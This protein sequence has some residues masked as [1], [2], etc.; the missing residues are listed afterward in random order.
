MEGIY[1]RWLRIFW[2]RK[3]SQMITTALNAKVKFILF[4]SSS[5]PKKNRF[6][7]IT[8]NSCFPTKKILLRKIQKSETKQQSPSLNHTKFILTGKIIKPFNC[9]KSRLQSS[10]RS[11]PLRRYRFRS[12]HSRV[13]KSNK[14]KVV[15]FQRFVC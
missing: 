7:S 8:P 1:W 4:R 12:L 13:Q 14:W 10:G 2:S 9:Q 15:W 5:L 6:L 3:P 11:K